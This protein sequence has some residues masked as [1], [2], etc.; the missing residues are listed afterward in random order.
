MTIREVGPRN[1]GLG[2]PLPDEIV[3]ERLV[4]QLA[5]RWTR[6]LVTVVAPGGYGKSIALAQ[7]IRDNETDPTGIDIYVRC[8]RALGGL[9]ELELA[10]ASASATPSVLPGSADE[11]ATRI[12]ELM[13]SASPQQVCLCLDDVHVMQDTPEFADLIEALIQGLPFN[14][15]LVLAGRSLPQMR[16]AKLRASDD[17][18]AVEESDLTFDNGEVGAL[19]AH[20]GVPPEQLAS[21]AG[22]PAVSRLL[23][24][25]DRDVSIEFMI[26]E[27]IARLTDS[28]RTALG[29]AVIAA[30]ATRELLDELAPDT[31]VP[32]LLTAVP[33]MSD[34]GGGAVAAHDLWHEVLDSIIDADEQAR[35]AERVVAFHDQQGEAQRSVD[36]ALGSGLWRAAL[37]PMMRVFGELD[38]NV[39]LAQ[40]ERWL[41][42]LPSAAEETPEWAFLAGLS[43]RL[44]GDL[45]GSTELIRRS[46]ADFEAAGDLEGAT[47][48]VLE[49]GLRSWMSSDG[50]LWAEVIDAGG[51]IIA[52][53]G[54]RMARVAAMAGAVEAERLG[55]FSGALEI[56]EAVEDR[57][58]LESGHAWMLAMLVGD[59]GR[60]L[61]HLHDVVDQSPRLSAASQILVTEWEA[62]NPQ[63]LLTAGSDTLARLSVGS[64]RD[65][66]RRL[67]AQ[68]MI[69]ANRGSDTG[70]AAIEF[71]GIDQSRQQALL[72]LAQAAR[73]LA[74]DGEQAVAEQFEARL[75]E[76]GMDD[77][78]LRGELRRYL[79]YP[80]ILSTRC[81]AWLDECD[82]LGPQQI[83]LRDLAR[84][85][86][87]GR[88]A[89][90]IGALPPPESILTWL[91]LPWSIE[92]AVRLK[93]A[94]DARGTDLLELLSDVTGVAAHDEVRRLRGRDDGLE[95][96]ASRVLAEIPGPPAGTTQLFVCR[97]FELRHDGGPPED[98]RLRVRQLLTLLIVRSDWT[99][100]QLID[101]LWPGDETRARTNLRTTLSHA[102][103]SIEPGR[104]AGEASFS[105]RQRADRVWLQRS[106][107]LTADLWEIEQLLD[108]AD[109]DEE[110]GVIESALRG[111]HAALQMWAPRSLDAIVELGGVEGDIEARRRR[112]LAAGG[113]AAERLLAAGQTGEA[114]RAAAQLLDID[115]NS[116]RAHDVA[117][118]AHLAGGELAEAGRAIDTVHEALNALDLAPSAGTMM[119]IRRY[120]RRR[121]QQG[122][123]VFSV[124]DSG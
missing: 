94:G 59:M 93:G 4:T 13:S 36:V 27:V 85:V 35:L 52:S 2:H 96:A 90:K 30:P 7:A 37:P 63:P 77:P 89:R 124:L 60:A 26:E 62:G 78:L 97:D 122:V 49:M 18:A 86:L 91:P 9:A 34:V 23:V 46:V 71:T 20:H 50:T 21:A 32:G 38:V 69:G 24:V 44:R 57:S 33:L 47:T 54:T 123:E 1:D 106:P 75:D 10:I 31:D 121:A 58:A 107:H 82:S 16:V 66:A 113:W 19:A 48:A 100:S 42:S 68:M 119:L 80:Y 22:W 112:V 92:L 84:A 105:L 5:E 79:P 64:S 25:A 41:V 120:A 116:E 11:L 8:R 45:D 83:E 17:L 6:R 65:A 56:Y 53:G 87:A 99:R 67:T 51:R 98:V 73:T 61:G 74:A 109:A 72:A 70:T 110:N 88:E 55:D 101:V 118:G 114:L 104:V 43:A 12:I 81:R 29:L 103:R 39:D 76:V 117:I 14:G 28:E 40:I 108:D 115:P 102:R 3:R 15:H 95:S 111:R